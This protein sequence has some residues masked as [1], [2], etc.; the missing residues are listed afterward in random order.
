MPIP[1]NQPDYFCYRVLDGDLK[2]L[3]FAMPWKGSLEELQT[4]IINLH[5]LPNPEK[6]AYRWVEYTHPERGWK[7]SQLIDKFGKPYAVAV[8]YESATGGSA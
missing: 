1:Y 7:G 3:A 4:Q 5:K 6:R 8:T 2:Q